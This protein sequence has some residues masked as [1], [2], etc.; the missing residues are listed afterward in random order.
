MNNNSAWTKEFLENPAGR[1]LAVAVFYLLLAFCLATLCFWAYRLYQQQNGGARID[2]GYL[3]FSAATLTSAVTTLLFSVGDMYQVNGWTWL[4]S[5]GLGGI[6]AAILL[7]IVLIWIALR[8]VPK[9]DRLLG[10]YIGG[11]GE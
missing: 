10:P 9:L 11:D 5:T 7:G 6:A 8:L 2:R 1:L 3:R 4:T